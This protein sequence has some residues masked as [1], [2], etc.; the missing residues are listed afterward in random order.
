M[1]APNST[2]TMMPPNFEVIHP[3]PFI[4][5][6]STSNTHISTLIFLHG[7]SQTGPELASILLPF[8]IPSPP[9]PST[10]SNPIKHLPELLLNTRFVFP[11]GA[12]KRTTV[13]GGRETNSWFDIHTFAD[14]TVGE[15]DQIPGLGESIAYLRNVVEEEVDIL[16]QGG[17]ARGEAR[18]RIVVA[19]FSSGAALT[20]LGMLSGE[21]EMGGAIG[22]YVGMSGWL[23][24]RSNIERVLD[25]AMAGERMRLA[26]RHVRDFLG[27][28][29]IK[30]E[31]EGESVRLEIERQGTELE[32]PQGGSTKILLCH[33]EMDVKVRYEW[34]AQMKDSMKQI[35]INVRFRSYPKLEHWLCGKE[36]VDVVEFLNETWKEFE[37]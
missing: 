27:F 15:D 25:A 5:A 36:I 32:G 6:P 35:G 23:P 31:K 19:G 10:T 7:T 1:F 3:T 33:G 20:A 21:W 26:R 11:T 24:F 4:H 22:G 14:R 8:P 37:V 17:M 12:P 9:I 18:K 29:E 16:V 34:G 13:F 28:D 30:K 2:A